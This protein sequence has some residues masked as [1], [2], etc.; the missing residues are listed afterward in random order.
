MC[1]PQARNSLH[2]DLDRVVHV[3]ESLSTVAQRLALQR[4]NTAGMGPKLPSQVYHIFYSSASSDSIIYILVR[5][6]SSA[7]PDD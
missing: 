6:L 4:V 3:N 1:N 5:P 2:Y 7:V